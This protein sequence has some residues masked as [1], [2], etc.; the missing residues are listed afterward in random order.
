MAPVTDDFNRT[1]TNSLGA[2]W[3]TVTAGWDATGFA[4]VSNAAA[5]QALTGD[6][7]EIYTGASFAT[8]HYAQAKVTVNATGAGTGVGVALR[9]ATDGSC[10]S[11][12]VS[13]RLGGEIV[14]ARRLAGNTSY[15]ALANPSAA[16]VDGD[17]LKAK[18]VGNVITV[19]QNGVQVESPITDASGSAL[20]SGSP[21]IVDSTTLTSGSLDDFEA[22][23]VEM[24]SF[25]AS[26]RRSVRR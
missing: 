3:T 6:D 17:T 26:R 23:S 9:G 20:T 4:I 12:I 7:L 13:K 14:V 16:W 10:Y 15:T 19:Y 8:D 2:N 25:Y 1:D 11:V 24:Q 22:A 21:G 5:P 18:I